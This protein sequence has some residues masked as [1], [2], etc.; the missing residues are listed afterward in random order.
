MEFSFFGGN[1][2]GEM[3][4]ITL[5]IE[6]ILG[7]TT[8]QKQTVQQPYMMA[9]A[10]CN[11]LARQI[12]EDDRPMKIIMRGTKPVEMPNGDWVSKPSSLEFENNA[13]I[14]SFREKEN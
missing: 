9:Q 11:N 12:A 4:M 14:R 1:P 13:Y 7:D 3:E 10:Q 2:F 8:L 5:E 6:I